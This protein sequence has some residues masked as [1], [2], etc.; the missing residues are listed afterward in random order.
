MKIFNI[1][2]YLNNFHHTIRQT[3]LTCLHLSMLCIYNLQNN[4]NYL[5]PA[6]Q[7]NLMRTNYK[8]DF[9]N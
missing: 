7:R 5:V 1:Y 2:H 9:V 6:Q 8:I 4:Y 3:C